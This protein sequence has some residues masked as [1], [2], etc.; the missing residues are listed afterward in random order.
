MDK[1]KLREAVHNDE[2]TFLREEHE[3]DDMFTLY[4]EFEGV[5]FSIPA[6]GND[7]WLMDDLAFITIEN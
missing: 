6:H 2:A 4:F 5:K 7:R 3:K 1:S